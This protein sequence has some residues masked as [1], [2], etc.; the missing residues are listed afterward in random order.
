[1]DKTEVKPTWGLVWGLFW[2]MFLISLGIY[3]VMGLIF[4]LLAGAFFTPF[5]GGW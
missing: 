5:M 3:A 4:F 2:R 1:M